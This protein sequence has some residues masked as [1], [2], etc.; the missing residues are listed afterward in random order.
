MAQLENEL[1]ELKQEQAEAISSAV[2]ESERELV[3]TKAAAKE[4]TAMLQARNNDL[5]SMQEHC[6]AAEEM[7]TSLRS[8]MTS[9]L[10]LKDKR[11]AHLETSKLTQ[12]QL[13]RIKVMKEERKKFQEDAKVLKKQLARLKAAYDELKEKQLESSEAASKATSSSSDFIISD[14]KFQVVEVTAQLTQSQAI[15]QTLKDKLRDCA[16]QLQVSIL[17]VIVTNYSYYKLFI[18]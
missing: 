10:E 4:L 5:Q 14:L 3:S 13:E 16:K 11:I 8:D 15:S 18:C 12:E 6:T 2:E 7:L 17:H 1:D 9:Q